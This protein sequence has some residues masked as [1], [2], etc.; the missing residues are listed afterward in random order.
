MLS[1]GGFRGTN[2]GKPSPY[3]CRWG[4]GLLTMDCTIA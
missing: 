2:R 3:P 4:M 1:I